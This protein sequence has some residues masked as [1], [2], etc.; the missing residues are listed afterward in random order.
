MTKVSSFLLFM[1]LCSSS[2]GAANTSL[3]APEIPIGQAL[4]LAKHH[5]SAEKIDVA[6]SYIASAEWHPRSGLVS[7]WRIEWR[8]KKA[9]KGGHTIVTVYADGKIEHGFGE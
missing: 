4:A 9:V 7:F 8:T 3:E 5:V 6:E 1:A 2:I